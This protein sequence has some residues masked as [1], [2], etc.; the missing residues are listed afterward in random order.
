MRRIVGITSCGLLAGM[1]IGTDYG[2]LATEYFLF[3]FV[4]AVLLAVLSKRSGE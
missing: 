3:L 2:G 1:S 4:T